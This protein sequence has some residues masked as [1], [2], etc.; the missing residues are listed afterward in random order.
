MAMLKSMQFAVRSVRVREK[1]RSRSDSVSRT[2]EMSRRPLRITHSWKQ[3]KKTSRNPFVHAHGHAT[4][5]HTWKRAITQVL[6]KGSFPCVRD[7]YLGLHYGSMV[8]ETESLLERF[9]HALRTL[10]TGN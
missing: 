9:F 1:N 8:L 5:T 10:H 3:L 4:H 6:G 2:T 7:T